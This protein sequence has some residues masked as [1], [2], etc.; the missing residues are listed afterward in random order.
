MRRFL[1]VR[2]LQL[3][4]L[5]AGT[6]PTTRILDRAAVERL[7]HNKGVT[8]QWISCDH[9]GRAVVTVTDGHWHLRAAQSGGSGRLFLDGKAA[10][11]GR[12]YFLFDGLEHRV[13]ILNRGIPAGSDL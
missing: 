4:A 8:L 2:A 7:G 1:L 11:I 5:A 3:V 6:S 12:D 9:R 10:E 13:D